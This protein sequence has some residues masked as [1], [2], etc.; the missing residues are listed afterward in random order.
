LFAFAPLAH[1]GQVSDP[2][3]SLRTDKTQMQKNGDAKHSAKKKS[4]TKDGMGQAGVVINLPW[5]KPD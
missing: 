1:A 5:S 4:T 3:G 2:V